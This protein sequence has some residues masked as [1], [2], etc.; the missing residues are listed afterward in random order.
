MCE[1]QKQKGDGGESLR[2]FIWE[3][4]EIERVQRGKERTQKEGLGK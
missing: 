4:G 3:G 1:N 2:G